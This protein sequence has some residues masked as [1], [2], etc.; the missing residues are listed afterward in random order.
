MPKK[1]AGEKYGDR[2]NCFGRGRIKTVLLPVPLGTKCF[3]TERPKDSELRR[4]GIC[5]PSF[6]HC[7]PNGAPEFIHACEAINIRPLCGRRSFT[8]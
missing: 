2:V 6:K 8:A 1:R 5:A 7:A 4:S 3:R